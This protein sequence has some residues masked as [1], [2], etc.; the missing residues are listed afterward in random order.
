MHKGLP[1]EDYQDKMMNIAVFASGRGTNFSAIARAVKKGMIK[2][3]LALLVCDQ[4]NAGVSAR[5]RRAGVKIALVERQDF[6]DNDGFE[7]E[8]IRHLED[9]NIGLILLA[10]YMRMLSRG[11]VERYKNKIINIHPSILPAFKG[12][13]SIKDAFEYGSK[14]T[15]VTVHFVDGEMD[16]GPIILQGAVEIREA[17]TLGALEARIHKLEHKLYPQA[18]NLYLSGK[19]KAEGRKVRVSI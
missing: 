13:E 18:V 2:A 11:F 8:I 17:D 12:T 15:G 5:A 6:K 10:G 3:N 4:P 14:L 7:A 9:N 19:L 1:R 16:H